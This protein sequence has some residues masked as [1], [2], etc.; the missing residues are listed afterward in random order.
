V[1][2]KER[3]KI[4]DM[5]LAE[6]ASAPDAILIGWNFAHI[7]KGRGLTQAQAAELGETTVAYVGKVETA[8]VSF[9]TR[10]QQKW[11]QIFKV[12]RTEFLRRPDAG[13]AVM[14]SVI[15]KGAVT[16]ERKHEVEY[17]PSLPGHNGVI[18]LKVSTDALYPRFRRNSYLYIVTVPVSAVRND[19]LVFLK[20]ADGPGAIKEVEWLGDG[21]ILFKGL[22]RGSTITKMA[23][24]LATMQKV[25]FICM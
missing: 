24:D 11:S 23:S 20:E 16:G 10:A 25:I 15:E 18:C 12:D 6:L 8:A 21:T 1:A 3:S 7:R 13:I 9:G 17:M 19:D 22:G 5:T 2:K 4:R 14:E